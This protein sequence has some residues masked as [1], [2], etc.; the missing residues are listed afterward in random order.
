MADSAV[1][2]DRLLNAKTASQGLNTHWIDPN[3]PAIPHKFGQPADAVA[4]HLSLTAIR[5]KH[6]HAHITRLAGQCQDEAVAPSA[7][8]AIADPP[9]QVGR[10]RRSRVCNAINVEIVVAATVKFGESHPLLVYPR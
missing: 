5:I 6:A 7:K 10:V 8:V 1:S 2:A 3:Q 9:G 4:A